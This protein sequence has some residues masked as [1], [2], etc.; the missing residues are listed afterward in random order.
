V[1]VVADSSPLIALAKI[2]R[3]ALLKTL[4]PHVHI[5]ADV[6]ISMREERGLRVGLWVASPCP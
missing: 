4:Y 6:M 3:F 1:I 5:S 2:G